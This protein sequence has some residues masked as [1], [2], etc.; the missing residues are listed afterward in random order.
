MKRGKIFRYIV[1]N[2][3]YGVICQFTDKA[4]K[5]TLSGFGSFPEDVYPAGRLDAESEGLVLLTNDGKL[6]H[7]LLDPLYRH[8]RKYLI[9]VEGIPSL[10]ALE[11]LREGVTVEKRKTLPAEVEILPEEPPLLPRK[12]PVRYRKNIPTS[13]L[14]ITLYEGRNRQVRKMTAAV[15]YPTLRL[16]RISIGSLDL[17]GLRP[18]EKRDL[19]PEEIENLR[20][21]T[22]SGGKAN[23]TLKSLNRSRPLRHP[24]R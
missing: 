16:V 21:S 1:L 14:G 11:R 22:I 12:V 5:D 13:W 3:P 20:Q 4:G 18:G 15:G 8:P 19:S 2:K 9:Q 17:G 24:P 7:R 10:E 23:L 6:K